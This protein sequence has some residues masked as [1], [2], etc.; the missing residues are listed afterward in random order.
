M[1]TIM[2]QYQHDIVLLLARDVGSGLK[3]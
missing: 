3:L 1:Y 2:N